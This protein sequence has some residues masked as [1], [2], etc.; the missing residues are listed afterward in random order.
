M[1]SARGPERAAVREK[2]KCWTP[3]LRYDGG[4]LDAIARSGKASGARRGYRHR[5]RRLRGRERAKLRNAGGDSRLQNA[6]SDPGWDVDRAGDDRGAAYGHRGPRHIVRH[7][8]GSRPECAALEPRGG[9]RDRQAGRAAA[10]GRGGTAGGL[11]FDPDGSRSMSESPAGSGGQTA[12][13]PFPPVVLGITGASG[14]GKP[15]LAVELART[16]GGIH[17]PLDHYYRDLSHLPFEERVLHNFDDP[18]LIESLL[19]AAQVAAL[20]QGKAIERPI[21]DFST[22]IRVPGKTEPVSAGAFL[23]VEGLLALYYPE[24]LPL[25]QLRIYVDRSEEH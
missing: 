15:T 6:G 9:L 8:Q 17:F 25:Y 3:L 23:I 12:R 24:L 5:R 14:S 16:L 19:L 21:Y 20:A 4:V 2:E 10:R 22:Y 11:D 18:R 1:E 7:Q 13:L